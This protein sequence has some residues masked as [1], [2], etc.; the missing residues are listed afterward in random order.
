MLPMKTSERA[1]PS[2]P[3]T[4]DELLEQQRHRAVQ[5]ITGALRQLGPDLVASTRLR[6]HA[7]RRPLLTA[8][9]GVVVG[10][11]T[12]RC[13]IHLFTHRPVAH[14]RPGGGI[15]RALLLASL[16]VLGR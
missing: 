9:V 2:T 16:R 3:R 8:G 13:A 6:S 12:A 14:T 4:C 5:H 1:L 15:L 11:I 10:L 7:A